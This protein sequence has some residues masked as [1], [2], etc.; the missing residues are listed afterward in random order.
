VHH[1]TEDG[2]SSVRKARL[3]RLIVCLLTCLCLWL[4]MH[5][6]LLFLLPQLLSGLTDVHSVVREKCGT[7]LLQI[8]ST[9]PV[10]ELEAHLVA[11]CS[12]LRTALPDQDNKTRQSWRVCFDKM[13]ALFP[14]Q[15]ESLRLELPAT[16]QKAIE[17]DRKARTQK[18]G[19]RKK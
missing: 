4:S 9:T 13:H 17:A 12:A 5:H 10:S 19:K 1:H 18:A 8:L 14:Q 11:L 7:Y 16:V 15:I 6:H 2:L 3:E